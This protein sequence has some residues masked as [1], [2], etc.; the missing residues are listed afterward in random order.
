MT[1]QD[2]ADKFQCS[3]CFSTFVDEDRYLKHKCTQMLRQEEFKT[4]RG[5]AAWSYYQKWFKFQQKKVPTASAFLK[6]K[7][8]LS[9]HRF[10]DFVRRVHLTDTD[11][12]VKMMIDKQYPPPMWTNDEVYAMYL[13][14]IDKSVPPT[15]LAEITVR[16]L[17]DLSETFNCSVTDVFLYLTSGEVL[18][19]I[20]E[21]KLTPWILLRSHKFK[22]FLISLDE[23]EQK[24]FES[25]VRA[26]YWMYKFDQNRQVVDWMDICVE[27][28]RI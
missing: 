26:P 7:Y 15:K 4:P 10:V 23:N 2:F 12:F 22:E 9:F 28:L 13:E 6:S 21:H 1:I 14:F 16:T 5:Q 18:Q 20:R 17:F 8:Y 3:F 11:L 19:L 27:E 24:L 25:L